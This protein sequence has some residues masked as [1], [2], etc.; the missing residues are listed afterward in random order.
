MHTLSIV[1]RRNSLMQIQPRHWHL[2][3]VFALAA[4]LSACGSDVDTTS[5]GTQTSSA[6]ST[7]TASSP[8]VGVSSAT[9][10]TAPTVAISADPSIVTSG[11]STTLTWTS[12]GAT[13]CTASGAWSGAEAVSGTRST[14]ALSADTTYTL[15]CTGPGG[16]TQQSTTITISAPVTLACSGS[17]GPLTLKVSTV[18]SSGISPFLM[19]FDATATT[20]TSLTGNTTAFQDVT[21]TWN[22][23]DFGASG[24]GTWAYGANAGHNS[25]N[26]ATG[27]IAAHL[28]VTPGTD[29]A[30]TATVTATDG[31]NT[32]S[33]QL[34][35]TAYDPAGTHGFAG[36]KTTCVSASGIPVPGSGDCPAGAAV[37]NTSSFNTA[38]G[39]SY[40]GSGKR[41]LFKCGDTFTGDNATLNGTTWSVGAY[42]GCEGTQTGRPIFNDTSSHYQLIVSPS[43]G[44]GRIADI[45]LEGNGTAAGAV[46]MGAAPTQPIPYQIT[47]SNLASSGN[48]AGY[49]WTQGAQW[50][51]IGSTQLNS[52]GNIAVFIN[53]NANNPTQWNGTYPNLNYQALI[54]NFVNGVGSAG[55]GGSGIEAMR[56]AAC[57]LCVYEN[58]TVENANDIGGVFKM[59]NG[60]TNGSLATWTGVYTELIEISD[61]L[62]TGNSGGILSDIAPQNGGDD[63]RLR[64]FVIERNLYSASTTAWGGQLLLLSGDNMTL[65]DNAFYM[66]AASSTLYPALGAQIAQRGAGNITVQYNEAY[67]NTCYAPDSQPTQTCIGFDTI[68][69]RSAPSINSFAK[70]NLFYVPSK[71]TG[72]A[73]DNTGS[74]NTVSN[75]TATVTNNPGFT[76]GS[77]DFSLISDFKPTENDTGGTSVPV[78]YDAL[79]VA[80][81]PTW[82][83]G[84]VHK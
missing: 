71:A 21:Y 3:L 39:A 17:S 47:L 46:S 82:G 10:S 68:G 44:N 57:R 27:G 25:K 22:F 14:G 67:N 11:G 30:Y 15:N 2:L 28:Y 61:N 48:S 24:T 6:S 80:W 31:T 79:D 76:D 38:L 36:T 74:G 69:S 41:V 75:N 60:N 45:S 51:L 8:T 66:P 72:P 18:R 20:D 29:T 33:C 63:E 23:G 58:N 54:G 81:S 7:S 34:G 35:V 49:Y 64:N 32:T 83:L 65:R 70:N 4:G 9:S 50:G 40:F 78:S 53:S 43:A 12:T 55:G 13:A 5:N 37:L 26:T 1:L 59:H 52:R 16:N 42:G 73:V 77:G 19:F 56:T 62:F 84:A